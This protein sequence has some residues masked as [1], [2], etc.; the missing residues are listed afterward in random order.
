MTKVMNQAAPRTS[1][2]GNFNKDEFNNNKAFILESWVKFI[3]LVLP[4]IYVKG[5]LLSL[6]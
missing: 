1:P 3:I 5:H 2:Y 4:F 6:N